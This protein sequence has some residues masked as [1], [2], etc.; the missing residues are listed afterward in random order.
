MSSTLR[1]RGPD[2][3]GTFV[4]DG[5]GLAARR[6]AII[7]LDAGDQPISNEDGS[8]TVVQN[9]EIYNYREL[10]R[11][12]ERAGHRFATQSDTETI[13][14]AY[15]EW[16]L[17]F[18]ERLRGMFAVAIW[19]A[20]RRRL[21][22]A[23][24]R[25]GIKPLYYRLDDVSLAFASELDALPRGEVDLDAL[26]AFLAFNSIPAPLSIFREI[27][28]LPARAPA[29]R[30]RPATASSSASPARA[31][32]SHVTTRTRPSSWRSAAH[33]CATRSGRTSSP[34]CP[35]ACCCRA[36]STRGRS[37][38]SRRRR[39]PKRCARSRSGSRRGRSTSCPARVPSRSAT[40]PCIAS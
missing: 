10:R 13:V 38:H 1:H 26:E 24:D 23:R 4:D 14:H 33:G 21:V 30:G 29:R 17:G 12:L 39:A 11:E 3:E 16:G 28:K 6:L 27:R 5:V 35:L 9:G 25:F 34:T 2:S 40:E 7:D 37:P 19:D 31:R 15:D 32:S 20:T 22:L 36:A 8:A 18:A